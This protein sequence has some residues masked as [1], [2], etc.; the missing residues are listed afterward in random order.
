[1]KQETAQTA[2]T[3]ISG[4]HNMHKLPVRKYRVLHTIDNLTGRKRWG[5]V[6]FKDN[7]MYKRFPMAYGMRAAVRAANRLNKEW[8]KMG[9]NSGDAA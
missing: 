1:M 2:Q 4:Y 9:G 6:W 7:V 3:T 8:G 5:V